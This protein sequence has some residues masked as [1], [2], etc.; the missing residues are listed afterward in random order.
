MDPRVEASL[1][2]VTA[3]VRA[4]DHLAPEYRDSLC[5]RAINAA[6]CSNGV[7]DKLQKISEVVAMGEL[8]HIRTEV[9]LESRMAGVLTKHLG[10]MKED[11][12]DIVSGAILEHIGQCPMRG[13][14]KSQI[15]MK[16]ESKE[17]E[18]SDASGILA[19]FGARAKAAMFVAKVVES[20][21]TIAGIAVL[22]LIWKIL[23]VI[24]ACLGSDG[25]KDLVA[26]LF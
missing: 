16:T 20:S 12:R 1:D 26:K 6:A 3:E 18:L 17:V 22:F 14:D 23:A 4:A 15:V 11:I 25:V 21:P 5:M 2:D 7:V 13:I 24:L 19:G 9:R 8:G 10:N